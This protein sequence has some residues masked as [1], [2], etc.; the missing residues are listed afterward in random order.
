MQL[1]TSQG[2][3][4]NVLKM[5]WPCWLGEDY[6]AELPITVQRAAGPEQPPWGLH[7]DSDDYD[8]LGT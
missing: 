6:L 2:M 4:K 3:P 5:A 7:R 1:V 8:C